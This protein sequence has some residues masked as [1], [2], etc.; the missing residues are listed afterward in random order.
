MKL[1]AVGDN[2]T[3][4]YVDDNVYYPGGNAV[5]VVV[6]SKR[7]GAEKASYIGIFGNDENAKWIQECLVKEEIDMSRS[8]KVYAHSA[9]PRV[10]LKNGDR[11]FAAGKR[12][13]CQHL[14]SIHLVT[15][16]LEII[17]EFDICHTSCY[18]NMEY[19]LATLSQVC[20]V[21]FDFSDKRDTEYLERVCPYITYAFF[22]ASD[23]SEEECQELLKLAATKGAKICGVTRGAKGSMF[24]DGTNFYTQGIVKT[25]VIDTMGAGDS[26]IAG[27]LT[28]Y[29]DTKNMKEALSF[30]A[31]KAAA[32]CKIHG[33]FGYPH[34]MTQ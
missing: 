24:Y 29:G 22:S 18:S 19:E 17:K 9:Q 8:R 31:T 33:G 14:F 28:N 16:D 21:S 27:F 15:E 25:E 20:D 23:L 7:D 11:V 30:A 5:N 12:D 2:V 6:N 3:D 4:C 10:L 26:F 1:I 34:P 13:S 32:T